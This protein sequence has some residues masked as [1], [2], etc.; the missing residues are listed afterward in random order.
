MA[1]DVLFAFH[2]QL[3]VGWGVVDHHFEVGWKMETSLRELLK[4]GNFGKSHF[5]SM[6]TWEAAGMHSTRYLSLNLISILVLLFLFFHLFF[7][8][9]NVLMFAQLSPFLLCI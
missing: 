4:R 5:V 9:S 7:T 8:Y 6:A 2:F 3:V 1:K